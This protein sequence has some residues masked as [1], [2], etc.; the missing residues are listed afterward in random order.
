VHILVGFADLAPKLF[1]Q[2]PLGVVAVYMCA[3]ITIFNR[4]FVDAL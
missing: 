3:E 4:S 1:G 2:T